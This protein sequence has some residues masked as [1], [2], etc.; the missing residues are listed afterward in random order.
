MPLTRHHWCSWCTRLLLPC[1]INHQLLY[2]GNS[3]LEK[4]KWKH[5]V[6]QEGRMNCLTI[7][8]MACN[9]PVSLGGQEKAG[10]EDSFLEMT[11]VTSASW[12][13][14]SRLLCLRD[15]DN[16]TNHSG[17]GKKKVH[18]IK[19]SRQWASIWDS[20]RFSVTHT[21]TYTQTLY[22]TDDKPSVSMWLVLWNMSGYSHRSW[23]RS[24]SQSEA[25][26]WPL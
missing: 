18:T 21:H 14:E 5:K 8:P 26:Y 23:Y 22:I 13:Q 6:K 25:M 4:W 9:I 17:G 19:F 1:S 12:I 2:Y 24:V 16:H 15:Y 10:K 3:I 7:W 11:E 20:S